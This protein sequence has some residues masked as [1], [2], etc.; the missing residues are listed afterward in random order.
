M[1]TPKE[2][3]IKEQTIIIIHKLKEKFGET[4]INTETIIII[5]KEC[6][7]LVEKFQYSASD[8][9]EYVISIVKRLI[10]ELVD[11]PTQKRILLDMI[12]QQI[13]DNM[14]DLVIM[15]SKGELNLNNI[16]IKKK[17]ESCTKTTIIIIIDGIINLLNKCLSK[18][19]RQGQRQEQQEPNV[20]K[21]TDLIN[22]L[23]KSTTTSTTTATTATTT[24]TT[25]NQETQN[26][27]ELELENIIIK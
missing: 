25:T 1:S 6:M 3:E 23:E 4:K 5:L 24:A 10:L 12:E 8:K 26:K 27:A 15:A 11:D 9:K 16:K 19:Q 20:D 14:I 22:N 18:T 17:V 13:L 21:M 7:E 2:Q